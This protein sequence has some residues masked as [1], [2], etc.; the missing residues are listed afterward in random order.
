ME[1]AGH[2]AVGISGVSPNAFVDC[3]LLSQL[4]AAKRMS[5]EQFLRWRRRA[6]RQRFAVQTALLRLRTELYER[7][8]KRARRAT[9]EVVDGG[10]EEEDEEEEGQQHE[11]QGLQG[12]LAFDVITSEDVWRHI[13]E[14]L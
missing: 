8:R 9:E 5:V 3:V 4:S 2:P 11:A 7:Q 14:F 13:L 1:D 10:E 12:K 6:P